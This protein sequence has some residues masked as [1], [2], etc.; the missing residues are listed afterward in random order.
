MFRAPTILR[1][2]DNVVH[3]VLGTC[4]GLNLTKPTKDAA[5]VDELTTVRSGFTPRKIARNAS[6][7][8]LAEQEEAGQK[9]GYHSIVSVNMTLKRATTLNPKP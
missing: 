3:I 4:K 8:I 9:T 1:N 5:D 7:G 2:S 6:R